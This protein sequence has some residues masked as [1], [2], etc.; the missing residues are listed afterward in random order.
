M[1]IRCGCGGRLHRMVIKIC[2][3]TGR[4][5]QRASRIANNPGILSAPEGQTICFDL[6]EIGF[7]CRAHA[8]AESKGAAE[9]PAAICVLMYAC[10]RAPCVCR[11]APSESHVLLWSLYSPAEQHH[12]P[13]PS[14]TATDKVAQRA[15]PGLKNTCVH[16]LVVVHADGRCAVLSIYRVCIKQTLSVFQI[17]LAMHRTRATI[18]D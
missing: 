4:C 10:A 13:N 17:P 5:G 1:E 12:G 2:P 14:R 16:S 18:H 7:I 11:R 15:G 8:E 3:C 6:C 9:R